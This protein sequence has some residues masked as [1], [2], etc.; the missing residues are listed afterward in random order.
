METLKNKMCNVFH[1]LSVVDH[2][3]LAQ[4]I[5]HCVLQ[6]LRLHLPKAVYYYLV[7]GVDMAIEHMNSH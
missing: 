1:L 7:G 4:V 6:E 5:V 2:S 3:R